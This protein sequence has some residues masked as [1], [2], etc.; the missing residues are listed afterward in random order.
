[1][2]GVAK[3][4][5]HLCADDDDATANLLQVPVSDLSRWTENCQQFPLMDGVLLAIHL[6]GRS[7]KRILAPLRR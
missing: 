5:S 7:A 1:M 2:D 6:D 3:E 4:L